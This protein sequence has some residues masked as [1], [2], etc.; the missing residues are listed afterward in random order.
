MGM[1]LW[2]AFLSS[3]SPFPFLFQMRASQELPSSLWYSAI[4]TGR[5]AADGGQLL[6]F[7]HRYKWHCIENYWRCYRGCYSP[8]SINK[9]SASKRHSRINSKGTAFCETKITLCCA[10]KVPS[11]GC[12]VP[13]VTSQGPCLPLKGKKHGWL[14]KPWGCSLSLKDSNSEKLGCTCKYTVTVPSHQNLLTLSAQWRSQAKYEHPYGL[15]SLYRP[16]LQPWSL[17]SSSQVPFWE[18]H[19]CQVLC[20]VPRE[21]VCRW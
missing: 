13:A 20:S 2:L 15:L 16:P 21:E 9:H 6:R 19:P 8:V 11:A 18:F 7:A 17:F 4:V 12:H 1:P 3:I 5:S 14:K 10:L